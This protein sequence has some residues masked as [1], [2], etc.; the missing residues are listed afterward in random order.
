[1]GEA[2]PKA[3]PSGKPFNFDDKGSP[4]G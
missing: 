4:K 1:G 3:P 2:P